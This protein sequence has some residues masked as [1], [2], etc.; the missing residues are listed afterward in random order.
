M[1][2]KRPAPRSTMH[3]QVEDAAVSWGGQQLSVCVWRLAETPSWTGHFWCPP[4]S[5]EPGS[6]RAFSPRAGP[7]TLLLVC[8][9]EG[10]GRS[11]RVTDEAPGGRLLSAVTWLV[12]WD[13]SPCRLPASPPPPSQRSQKESRD[14]DLTVPC[15]LGGCKP[16]GASRTVCVLE[17]VLRHVQSFVHWDKR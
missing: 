14:Q 9:V 3:L 5:P 13:S 7:K 11:P 2:A 17:Q 16:R 8:S 6:Q 1:L 10:R 4:V 12:T 15:P